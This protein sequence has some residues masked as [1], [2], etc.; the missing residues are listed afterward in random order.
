[1]LSILLDDYCLFLNISIHEKS[2]C[3]SRFQQKQHIIKKICRMTLFY[4]LCSCFVSLVQKDNSFRSPDGPGILVNKFRLTR[5]WC[6][7]SAASATCSSHPCGRSPANCAST[8]SAHGTQCMLD[9]LFSTCTKRVVFITHLLSFAWPFS[10]TSFHD[11]TCFCSAILWTSV[12][13]WCQVIVSKLLACKLVNYTITCWS[14]QHSNCFKR[15]HKFIL[16]VL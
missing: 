2:F 7:A 1:M 8:K 15:R 16:S 6:D 3:V 9:T 12:S 10:R 14:S 4:E 13:Q 11:K 5:W